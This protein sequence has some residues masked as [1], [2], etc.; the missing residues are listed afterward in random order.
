MLTDQRGQC[1]RDRRSPQVDEGSVKAVSSRDRSRARRGAGSNRQ[2][3]PS[4]AARC[5]CGEQRL[6][7]RRAYACGHRVGQREHGEQGKAVRKWCVN[8]LFQKWS[9]IA[10]RLFS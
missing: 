2:E 3:V 1:C 4:K 9:D 5:G 10:E 6:P 7:L 8:L